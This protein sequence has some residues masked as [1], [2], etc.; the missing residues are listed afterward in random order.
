MRVAQYTA[1]NLVLSTTLSYGYL[2]EYNP[3]SCLL[4]GV[5]PT[6]LAELW[7]QAKQIR[8]DNFDLFDH[9]ADVDQTAPLPFATAR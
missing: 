4:S 9:V 6:N 1:N 5:F 3:A 7:R 2:V 8:W